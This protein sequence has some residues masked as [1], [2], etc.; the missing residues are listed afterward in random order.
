MEGDVVIAYDKNPVCP[1]TVDIT[2]C[3]LM[4]IK[5][6]KGRQPEFV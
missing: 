1:R 5:R 6:E 4:S 2:D 3:Q